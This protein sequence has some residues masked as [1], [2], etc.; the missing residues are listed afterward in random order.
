MKLRVILFVLLIPGLA[1]ALE[2]NDDRFG[3]RD[4]FELEWVSDPQ[5]APAEA[6]S[7][8]SAKYLEMVRN[9]RRSDR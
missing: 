4:I 8:I 1:A 5:I 3:L 7:S 9:L 2:H 6:T